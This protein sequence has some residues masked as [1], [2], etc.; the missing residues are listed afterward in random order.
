MLGPDTR[1]GSMYPIRIANGYNIL[2]NSIVGK[3]AI[4][5]NGY[6]NQET[7]V[8]KISSMIRPIPSYNT[9]ENLEIKLHNNNIIILAHHSLVRHIYRKEF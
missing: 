1:P 7:W 9:K 3:Y 4:R 8:T 5:F 6:P 2:V